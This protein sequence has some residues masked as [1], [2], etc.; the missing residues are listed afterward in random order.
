MSAVL[1]LVQGSDEWHAHRQ[2][3]RNASEA[4]AVLGISPWVTPYRL[5]LLKTG[6]ATQEVS[7]AMQ[8]GTQLEPAARAAYE[9][10]TGLVMQPVVMQDGLYSASLDGISLAGDLIVEIKVP[11]RGRESSLW[12]EVEAGVVPDHYLAQ[13]QAQLVV[14]GAGLANLWVFDGERGLLQVV[15]LKSVP[16]AGGRP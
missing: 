1:R 14:S 6:R 5:W 7:A 11:F 3:M 13:I 9:L 16:P 8:R 10:Q 12:R 15:R 4:A 2:T